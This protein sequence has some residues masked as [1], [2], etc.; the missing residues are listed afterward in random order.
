[1]KKLMILLLV[2]C[3][4][5]LYSQDRIVFN[6][7]SLNRVMNPFTGEWDLMR[8]PSASGSEF[9]G[10]ATGDLDMNSY[11]VDEADTVNA[12]IVMQQTP[13]HAYYYLTTS[14]D[15]TLCGAD[16]G[17]VGVVPTTPCTYEQYLKTGPGPW[18]FM[19][20]EQ[21]GFSTDANDTITYTGPNNSYIRFNVNMTFLD[22]VTD[23]YMFRIFNVTKGVELKNPSGFVGTAS[24]VPL[25]VSILA[26]YEDADNGDEFILQFKSV[27]GL[28][29]EILYIGIEAEVIHY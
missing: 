27:A 14:G 22:V 2:L 21:V 8:L 9:V 25:N 5:Y 16:P 20:L 10:S 13:I 4:T 3:G 7:D 6:R 28:Q 11:N 19:A 17:F 18:G 15:D 23:S 26:N 1:M 29:A 24:T 12:Q